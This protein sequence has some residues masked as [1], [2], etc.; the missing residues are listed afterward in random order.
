MALKEAH[1]GTKLAGVAGAAPADG[2]PRPSPM[3]GPH[4]SEQVRLHQFGQFVFSLQWQRLKRYAHEQGL[5][6]IGDLPIFVSG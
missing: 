1:G 3:R 5:R 6:L 4:C 2:S